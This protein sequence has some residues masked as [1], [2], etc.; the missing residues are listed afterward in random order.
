MIAFFNL[1][2]R[3]FMDPLVRNTGIFT[4]PPV[5]QSTPVKL[6]SEIQVKTKQIVQSAITQLRDSFQRLNEGIGDKFSEFKGILKKDQ[7]PKEASQLLKSFSEGVQKVVKQVSHSVDARALKINQEIKAIEDKAKLDKLSSNLNREIEAIESKP[8]KTADD[9]EK[10]QRLKLMK[11]KLE[12]DPGFILS[13]MDTYGHGKS[14][15]YTHLKPVEFLSILIK[16]NQNV[17]ILENLCP[18]MGNP[19]RLSE[20]E[21]VAL[22]NYTTKNYSPINQ[23]GREAKETGKPIADPGMRACFEL[24]EA[25]RKKLPDAP[26]THPDGTPV[27]LKRIYF[28]P[29]GVP[30]DPIK[31][32]EI[33][34]KFK[35]FGDKNFVV[36]NTFNDG[37]F[38]SSS[39]KEAGTGPY[40]VTFEIPTGSPTIPD[41]KKIGFPYSAFSGVDKPDEGEVLF[42]PNIEFKVSE[43]NGSKITFQFPL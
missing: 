11:G 13:K 21:R 31:T 15:L 43:V 23:A 16:S 4:K 41:G 40:N 32:K 8:I 36:G 9:I 18:G 39:V 24:T 28:L 27:T 29:K 30:G 14:A 3:G 38:L 35:A 42:G 34:D 5:S 22:Y 33:E 25:A 12:H 26:S 2:Y 17:G 6:L 10:L 37:A 1:L 19:S 20:E 7:P